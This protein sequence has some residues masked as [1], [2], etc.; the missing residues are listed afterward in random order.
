[1]PPDGTVS[2]GL[3]GTIK[4]NP[5]VDPSQGGNLNLLRDGGINGPDYGYNTT[6]AASFAGRLQGMITALGTPQAFDPSAGLQSAVSVVDFSTASVGWLENQRQT[7]STTADTES[8]MVS[9]ASDALS[10]A[11]GVNID[12]EYAQQLKL[13]QSYQA[14][15][16]LINVID[17][18][19]QS[20]FDAIPVTA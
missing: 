19:M 15:S 2:P 6:G 3:A 10:N 8:A 11:T 5:A 9:E 13:E 12:D 20:L 18:M 16:K 17:T 1:M 14:S 4:L 7:A